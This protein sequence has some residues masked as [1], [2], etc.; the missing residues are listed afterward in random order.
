[1]LP[2]TVQVAALQVGAHGRLFAVGGMDE[3]EGVH[4]SVESYVP[5]MNQWVQVAALGAPRSGL[6]LCGV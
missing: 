5:E 6:G 2:W 3:A 1:M 4:G